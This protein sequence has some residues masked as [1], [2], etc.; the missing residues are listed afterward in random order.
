M[1]FL[2]LPSLIKLISLC[3]LPS[4]S[5]AVLNDIFLWLP[6]ALNL[7][8]C[9]LTCTDVLRTLLLHVHES[10]V[11]LLFTAILST[12][13]QYSVEIGQ[14][15]EI[16]PF[17]KTLKRHTCPSSLSFHNVVAPL[18]NRIT[19]S[20]S[21]YSSSC[22]LACKSYIHSF[23]RLF[24]V[25]AVFFPVCRHSVRSV[26]GSHIWHERAHTS[27]EPVRKGGF[28]QRLHGDESLA[29]RQNERMSGGVVRIQT[30]LQKNW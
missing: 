11:R 6:P 26:L 12:L 24:F 19:W 5:C 30:Y 16:I 29:I 20:I 27:P 17:Q 15:K 3:I 1:H 13:N 14:I 10:V 7:S 9:F 22:H 25:T 21:F 4:H 18:G 28:Q 23:S 8:H 2:A